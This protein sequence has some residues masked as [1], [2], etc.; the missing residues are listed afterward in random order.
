MIQSS[1]RFLHA[2]LDVGANEVFAAKDSRRDAPPRCFSND[3]P[4]FA[5]LAA[6]LTRGRASRTVRVCMEATGAYSAALAAHLH[7]I[8]GIEVMV[9]NPRRVKNFMRARGTRAKTDPIDALGILDYAKAVSFDP[10]QPPRHQVAAVRELSRRI[11]DLNTQIGRDRNRIQQVIRLPGDNSDTI[12]SIKR[13]IEFFEQELLL[14]AKRAAEMIDADEDMRTRARL[15][16]SIPGF[17]SKSVVKLVPELSAITPDLCAKQWVAHAGIDPKTFQSGSS[18]NRPAYISKQGN[19]YI[20]AALYM[21]AL[22][23]MRH[24]PHIRAFYESMLARGKRKKVAIVAIMRKLLVAI[25]A[26][27][28]S[29][30]PFDGSLFN[31][32]A[33]LLES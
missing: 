17:A 26:I 5:K 11:C 24:D 6:F 29:G 30:Q 13:A 23:A 10:W 12:A 22:V 15:I 21:P 1:D 8:E 31:P 33:K 27:F 18:I 3:R 20:R 28:K 14:L 32:N 16:E 9:A 25:H 4:G 2:G 7:S 19:R